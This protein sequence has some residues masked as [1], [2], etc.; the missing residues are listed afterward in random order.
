MIRA[1]LPPPGE[2]ERQL[3]SESTLR[4]L[5]DQGFIALHRLPPDIETAF[6]Q[7]A[8]EHAAALLHLS[9]Y[10]LIALYL[11]V[12][13]PISLFSADDRL[14]TWQLYAMLPIGVV[15][16]GIWVTTRLPQMDRHVETTLCISLFLCL[17]G[18]IYCAMLLGDHYYGQM[19]SYETIYILIVVFS[20][21]RLP[22]RLTL[23]WSLAA[24]AQAFLVAAVQGI[25]P[26]WL[27]MLLYFVVPLLICTVIGFMLEYS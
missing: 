4:R 9:I 23:R 1:L 10:G 25:P 20:V 15:L 24:F 5:L 19:A 3:A 11:L 6:R 2:P 17:C 8:R 16:A 7:H 12:V 27:N 18:T 22:T 21:L 14:A 13:V 26:L